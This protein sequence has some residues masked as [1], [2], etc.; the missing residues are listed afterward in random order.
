MCIHSVTSY[1]PVSAPRRQAIIAQRRRRRRADERTMGSGEIVAPSGILFSPCP[2][3]PNAI[4]ANA[5]A[6]ARVAVAGGIRGRTR[7]SDGTTAPRPAAWGVM[8]RSVSGVQALSLDGRLRRRAEGEPSRRAPG[9]SRLARP[10]ERACGWCDSTG[11]NLT[12]A[13][14]QSGMAAEPPSS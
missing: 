10:D 9:N 7:E 11:V 13:N 4:G 5:A 8:A 1:A 12:K 3:C 14:G 2:P 6:S